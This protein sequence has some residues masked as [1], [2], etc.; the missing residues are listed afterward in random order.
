[1]GELTRRSLVSAAVAVAC[2]CGG[3]M[4]QNAQPSAT[5]RVA[6]KGYDP[7]S[8]F[9]DGKPE[10]GSS[11]FNFAFDGTTYWFKNA[12]HKARFAADP[13]HYAPQ[14]DGYCAVQLSRGIKV[15]ADPESWAIKDGKLYV[16]AVKAGM[17]HFREHGAAIAEKAVEK[18]PKL[19]SAQ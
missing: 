18:W 6:L 12:D 13:A 15:E 3:A 14:F 4:A 17:A 11:E 7:V 16:F 2:Y 19:R 8:Y 5:N 9:T 1:M 10:M